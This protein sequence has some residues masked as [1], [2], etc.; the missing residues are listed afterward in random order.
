MNM[1]PDMEVKG[2]IAM[3]VGE[4]QGNRPFHFLSKEKPF[5]QILL[6]HR[7][8]EATVNSK[9]PIVAAR[10]HLLLRIKLID[11]D[12]WNLSDSGRLKTPI[13]SWFHPSFTDAQVKSGWLLYDRKRFMSAL[14][15]S[16]ETVSAF[17]DPFSNGASLTT[18]CFSRLQ[19]CQALS[20]SS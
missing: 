5:L 1:P 13:P 3:W 17:R 12:Q 19:Q 15:P 4:N 2:T 18:K 9:A 11:R 6:L 20:A 8:Q 10:Q 16:L 14:A 7:F